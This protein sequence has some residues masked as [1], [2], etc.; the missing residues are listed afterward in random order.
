[1]LL[2]YL[3]I[4]QRLEIERKFCGNRQIKKYTRMHRDG[5]TIYAIKKIDR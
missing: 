3:D 5:Y 4:K 1:M 2:K